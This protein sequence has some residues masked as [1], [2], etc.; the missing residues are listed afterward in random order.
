MR[1]GWSS[2]NSLTNKIRA[3]VVTAVDFSE[4]DILIRENIKKYVERDIIEWVSKC[5]RST[6][7]TLI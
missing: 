3:P 2:V 6:K 4:G 5:F 1:S 7:D